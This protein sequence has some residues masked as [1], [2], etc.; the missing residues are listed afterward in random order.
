MTV[1]R[2]DESKKKCPDCKREL[3]KSCFVRVDGTQSPRGRRCH[4]C[5]IQHNYSELLKRTDGWDHCVYCGE[6]FDVES[7]GSNIEYDHMDAKTRG[8]KDIPSNIQAV[9]KS[10][11]NK[12]GITLFVDWL[13]K[14]DPERAQISRETYIKK[15]GKAPEDFIPVL[16]RWETRVDID[17]NKYKILEYYLPDSIK[18]QASIDFR[19]SGAPYILWNNEVPDRENP[20]YY[21]D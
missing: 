10:C 7:I 2:S 18:D 13:K 3:P 6:M 16:R 8:G 21:D 15:Q 1:T 11:N 12:K 5:H 20:D 19:F 17:G 4:D 14:L 9:C